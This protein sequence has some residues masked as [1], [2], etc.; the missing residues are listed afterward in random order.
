MKDEVPST[1]GQGTTIFPPSVSDSRVS[2]GSSGTYSG[3]RGHGGRGRF[4]GQ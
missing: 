1:I 3:G 4:G 2:G